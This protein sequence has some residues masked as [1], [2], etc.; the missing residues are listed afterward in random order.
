M[1]TEKERERESRTSIGA[2]SSC[3]KN[4]WW[5]SAEATGPSLAVVRPPVDKRTGRSC[6]NALAFDEIWIIST[7]ELVN[8]NAV[9]L[10]SITARH[11]RACLELSLQPATL[12]AR[13]CVSPRFDFSLSG[14]VWNAVDWKEFC[15]IDAVCRKY[16]DT[17]DFFLC[18]RLLVFVEFH[19]A[20]VR[21]LEKYV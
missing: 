3:S 21:F 8:A 13:V 20:N 2:R 1:K 6:A 9:A 5:T 16:I 14:V 18:A 4:G 12:R 17:G 11:A 19:Y 7:A 15:W 10:R